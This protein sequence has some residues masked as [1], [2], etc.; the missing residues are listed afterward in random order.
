MSQ[1]INYFYCHNDD[2]T[3]SHETGMIC[4]KCAE[5]AEY[6]TTCPECGHGFLVN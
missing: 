4:S 6:S 5:S 2:A 3:I 1:C